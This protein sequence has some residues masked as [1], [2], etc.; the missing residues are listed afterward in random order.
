MVVGGSWRPGGGPRRD[1]RRRHASRDRSRGD[2]GVTS[3]GRAKVVSVPRLPVAV[4]LSL[5]PAVALGGYT[6]RRLLDSMNDP[7]PAVLAAVAPAGEVASTRSVRR[8]VIVLVDGADE[9]SFEGA[10]RDGTLAPVAWW[11]SF[12]TGTPSLSRPGYHALFTGAPQ[13]VSG[14]RNNAYDGPAR[15]DT[16]M[17]RARDAGAS[18]AWA[19][20][21]VDWMYALAGRPGEVYLRGDDALDVDRV[22][23]LSRRHALVLVH[24]T[25]SDH[26]GHDHGAASPEYQRVVRQSLARASALHRRLA[27]EP[28]A[29]FVGSDHGHAAVG[30]HGGPEP[31]VTR[32]R[33][34]RLGVDRVEDAPSTRVSATAMAAT[35]AHAMGLPPPRSALACGLRATDA[36]PLPERFCREAM[37][38]S[39]R[40]HAARTPPRWGPRTAAMLAVLAAAGAVARRHGARARAAL[41]AAGVMALG[42][43]VG[44]ALLG[45]GWTLTA[46]VTHATFLARTVGATTVGASAVWA[47]LRA[48]VDAREEDVALATTIAPAL[49]LAYALGSSGL[50]LTGEVERLVAPAAGLF[51]VAAAVPLVWTAW[52]RP[53]DGS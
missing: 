4:A 27:G 8:A 6:G 28:V 26:A 41:L 37:G 24:W 14:V 48:R 29:L 46:I 20:E 19:L 2:G 51:P 33:W 15:L 10:M 1:S 23:D 47:G 45:G 25:R 40:A 18:V 42:A 21:T 16:L 13:D 49:A 5:V 32:I 9:A 11:R 38:R 30:G 52:W 53:R 7:S 12:D 17:D 36:P 43:L 34:V 31:E 3:S 50:T 35:I 39:A 44:H 22:A